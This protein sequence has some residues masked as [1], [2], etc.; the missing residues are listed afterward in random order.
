MSIVAAVVI[1]A[2]MAIDLWT[3]RR[4][5]HRINNLELDVE[6]LSDNV[7]YLTHLLEGDDDEDED[8]E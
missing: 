5:E 2:Y 6:Y 3:D 8:V 1:V 4:A 7:T